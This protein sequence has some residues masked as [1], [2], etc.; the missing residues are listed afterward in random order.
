MTRRC[1][2]AAEHRRPRESGE[3]DREQQPS[4]APAGGRVVELYGVD[5]GRHRETEEGA[6]HRQQLGRLAAD[7]QPPA[8]QPADARRDDRPLPAL[9]HEVE[10]VGAYLPDPH[11]PLLGRRGQKPGASGCRRIEIDRLLRE[12][13]V[14]DAHHPRL[15]R[16]RHRPDPPRDEEDRQRSSQSPHPSA[17]QVR[18]RLPIGPRQPPAVG[19]DQVADSEHAEDRGVGPHAAGGPGLGPRPGAEAPVDDPA[20]RVRLH[21]V[22]APRSPEPVD[23]R[24]VRVQRHGLPRHPERLRGLAVPRHDPGERRRRPQV[25]I[26]RHQGVVADSQDEEVGHD[27]RQGDRRE[28]AVQARDGEARQHGREPGERRSP[29]D[30][31]VQA[32]E[33]RRLE[34]DH[35]GHGDGPKRC[36]RP[37]PERPRD[38]RRGE[39]RDHR[40]RQHPE[41]PQPGVRGVAEH[42][43]RLDQVEE[44]RDVHRRQQ[45]AEAGQEDPRQQRGAEHESAGDRDRQHGASR[46]MADV[47]VEV[48]RGLPIAVARAAEDER[49][50]Q[51]HQDRGLELRRMHPQAA[52]PLEHRPT[53]ALR[54]HL[55][56]RQE[57]RRREAEGE[58]RGRRST[59][60]EARAPDLRVARE[61]EGADPEREERRVRH[62]LRMAADGESHRRDHQPRKR[63]PLAPGEGDDAQDDARDPHRDHRERVVEPDDRVRGERE[64]HPAE[65]GAGLDGEGRGLGRPRRL[66]PPRQT[67]LPRQ[68]QHQG[69]E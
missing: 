27:R 55:E 44:R 60:G 1:T 47:L 63:A 31:L 9:G 56:D 54:Q 6:V 19:R 28:P 38:P 53:L 32:S 48:A 4:P 29:P 57:R 17:G 26:G 20:D 66:R 39:A 45:G 52:G 24:Q 3:P 65:R 43:Q 22:V 16:I 7:P 15:F 35:R 5:S 11:A 62:R 33:R 58:Q 40:H 49:L 18:N 30:S 21:R 59:A 50:R 51:G 25:E 8:A 61:E 69:V 13:L 67:R 37:S 23:R 36:R 10:A 42:R 41:E 2:S 34:E 68:R 46:V 14:A 64:R 12:V